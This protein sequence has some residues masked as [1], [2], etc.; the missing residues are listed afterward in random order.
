MSR[1]E[2]FLIRLLVCL[3]HQS[4]DLSA[5]LVS[6]TQLVKSI[7]E[8]FFPPLQFPVFVDMKHTPSDPNK[9]EQIWCVCVLL[10]SSAPFTF[11]KIRE[12]IAVD[13]AAA[14]QMKI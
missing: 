10:P 1:R 6:H 3:F 7:E 9:S 8:L 13:A 11:L 4:F 5:P 14:A 12:S 2:W